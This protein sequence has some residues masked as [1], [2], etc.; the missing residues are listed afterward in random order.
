M[1]LSHWTGS[2]VGPPGVRRLADDRK[3]LKQWLTATKTNQTNNNNNQT[4]TNFKQTSFDGR[5]YELHFICGPNYPV[6]PPVVSFRTRVNLPCV[7]ARNGE[8]ARASLPVLKGWVREN[9]ME[10]RDCVCAI[11]R[12]IDFGLFLFSN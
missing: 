5:I 12:E 9:R 6:E 8:V 1:T 4:T 2:I 11:E 7:N 10:V 3:L